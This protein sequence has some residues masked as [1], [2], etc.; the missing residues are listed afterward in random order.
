MKKGRWM[1]WIVAVACLI[2]VGAATLAGGRQNS[3][4]DAAVTPAPPQP[5]TINLRWTASVPDQLC[6]SVSD[7][8]PRIAQYYVSASF[9]PDNSYIAVVTRGSDRSAWVSLMHTETARKVGDVTYFTPGHVVWPLNV[10]EATTAVV[11]PEGKVVLAYAA[12]DPTRQGLTIM[13]REHRDVF[14]Y[15]LDGAIW[16]AAVSGDGTYAAVVTGGHSL[17]IFSLTGTPQY[18]RISLVGT[19]NSIKISSDGAFIASGT[20]D[21]S[22]VSCF[23]A[24]GVP[25]WRYQAYTAQGRPAI[26][27]LFEAEIA[28]SSPYLLGVS[29]ANIA[30]SSTR[31]YLWNRS[32]SGQ[33]LWSHDLGPEDFAPRARISADGTRIAIAYRHKINHGDQSIDVGQLIMYDRSGR[34]LWGG[35]RGGLLMSPDLI[36]ISPDGS[37]VTVDDGQSTL[38]NYD[39]DGRLSTGKVMGAA[40]ENTVTSD[41]GSYVLVYT[42]D[43]KLTLVQPASVHA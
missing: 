33:L 42:K 19:G 15:V 1:V 4:A 36:A 5:D 38:Y 43:N 26:N 3:H 17:Y 31:L 7:G 32:S 34:R 39:M 13:Q 29:Y 20:W 40:I 24:G 35:A 28:H 2:A 18:R 37:I 11:G 16:D 41:D 30:Q 12:L 8:Q 6:R 27:R 21:E 25:L 14:K 10:P 22:G 9:S 23:R